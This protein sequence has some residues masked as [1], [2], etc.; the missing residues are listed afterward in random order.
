MSPA[1]PGESVDDLARDCRSSVR[2]RAWVEDR[3]GAAKDTGLR[4][5]PIGRHLN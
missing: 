4:N 5:L 3:I 1:R 2:R